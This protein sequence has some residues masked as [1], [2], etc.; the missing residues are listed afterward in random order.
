MLYKNYLLVIYSGVSKPSDNPSV[1]QWKLVV[2]ANVVTLRDVFS[3]KA[4]GDIC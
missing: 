4:F 1:E 2:N 3:T